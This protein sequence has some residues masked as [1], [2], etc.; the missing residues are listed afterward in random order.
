VL[1]DAL[2]GA[3]LAA[4]IPPFKDD[5]NTFAMGDEM[6]LQ[7]D[8]LDLQTMQFMLIVL[9]GRRLWVCRRWCAMCHGYVPPVAFAENTAMS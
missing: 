7:F 3:V 1:D 9:F 5:Q 4:T 8:Q 2:D 6:L